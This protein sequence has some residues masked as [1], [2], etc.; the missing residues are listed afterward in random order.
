V[1]SAK[2]INL[3]DP[4][5]RGNWKT[6]EEESWKFEPKRLT[7]TGASALTML[8]YDRT[9]AVPCRIAFDLEVIQG[10]RVRING[11]GGYTFANE[12]LA[13]WFA[14]YPQV[15]KMNKFKYALGRKYRVKIDVTAENVQLRINNKLVDTRSPGTGTAGPF[16]FLPGDG[17]SPGVIRLS[18]MEIV[19]EPAK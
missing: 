15:A 1:P 18:D 6:A 3:L 14:L 10:S 19:G 13:G 17:F 2:G 5:E 9:F 12:D 7:G 16:R 4:A 11:F 8:T